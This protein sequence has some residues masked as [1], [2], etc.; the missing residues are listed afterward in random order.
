MQAVAFC[1]KLWIKSSTGN[2]VALDRSH[3][4]SQIAA[5][6]FALKNTS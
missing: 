2:L 6:G 4:V 3:H 5:E 1:G